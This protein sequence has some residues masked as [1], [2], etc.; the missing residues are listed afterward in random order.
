MIRGL[1]FSKYGTLA[2]STRQRFVQA[3][4]Y[5]AKE[6]ITIDIE[7][8]FDNEYLE[9][10]FSKNKRSP[11]KIL[12]AY[13]ARLGA[14]L[15]AGEYDFVWVHCELLPYFPGWMDALIHCAKKPVIYDFDDAIFHQYDQHPNALVRRLLGNKLAPLLKRSKLAFCGNA[16]LEHYARRYC[17]H[18]EVIPTTVDIDTY[19]PAP[20][21]PISQKPVL[22]WIGSPSTWNY[23]R[24]LQSVFSGFVK[25]G[26]LDV[27]IIGAGS[28]A[29][30]GNFEFRDWSERREVEDI[31]HMDIGM[32]PIPDKPWARG[33]CGYKLIQYM[34]CGLPVIASP[35]GVNSVIVEHGVNGFLA[36][37][38]AEWQSAIEQL[39]ADPALRHCMGQAGREKV[40][41]HYS[42]QVQGPRIAKAIH[43]VVEEA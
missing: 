33:K 12:D 10:L 24:P 32:M 27:L 8:L 36:S 39:I 34:A 5:L 38:E 2:A 1:V 37:T 17:N 18:T 42:I 19:V 35:V 31:R 23:C 4:P 26:K 9:A 20:P 40:E 25:A 30:H 3:I 11:F 28:T 7:P 13:R 21:K 6:G 16:Y 41:A 14:M 15:R 29:K 43:H 22:G